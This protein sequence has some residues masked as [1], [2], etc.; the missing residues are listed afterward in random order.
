M[1]SIRFDDIDKLNSLVSDEYGPWGKQCLISQEGISAF[2]QLT[3]D[4]QWIH[5]DA[6]R[7]ETDSPFGTTIAHG[8]FVLS[9]ITALCRSDGYNI[10]GHSSALNYGIEHLRFIKPVL[11]GSQIHCRTRIDKVTEKKGGTMIDLG[12]AVHIVGDD[13]PCLVLS[14]KLF[15]RS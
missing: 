13:D 1:N 11:A 9:F 10:V 14:W 15:Y 4:M 5:V 8:F 2:G 7:A 6:K 12:V 3:E